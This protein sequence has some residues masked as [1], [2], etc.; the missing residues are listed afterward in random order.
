M[1]D[2]IR[3]LRATTGLR[4]PSLVS[5]AVLT[6]TAVAFFRVALLP[7]FGRELSMSTFQLGLVTTV[8]AVG[9]LV[10]DLPGGATRLIQRAD[11]YVS[12]IKS[13]QV[14]LVDGE[15]TG[16]RPGALLRGAR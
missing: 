3:R 2:Y 13:G 12:T 5:A 1:R 15:D 8:F 11:G 7:E 14:T 16:A 10:A 4:E 9:R 6:L